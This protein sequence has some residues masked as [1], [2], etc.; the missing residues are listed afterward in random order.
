VAEQIRNNGK[1]EQQ[2]DQ[3]LSTATKTDA[4]DDKNHEKCGDTKKQFESHAHPL[5]LR[6]TQIGRSP[7]ASFPAFAQGSNARVPC[8][9]DGRTDSRCREFFPRPHRPRCNTCD[10]LRCR[11]IRDGRTF[12]SCL[13]FFSLLPNLNERGHGRS[14]PQAPPCLAPSPT[15]S[16][17]LVHP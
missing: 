7:V 12:D 13:T 4:P 17:D 14:R 1:S 8:N 11:C 2:V 3:D 16:S 5:R 9:L 6:C 15:R 10:P